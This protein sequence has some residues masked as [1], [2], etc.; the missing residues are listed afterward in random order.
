MAGVTVAPGADLDPALL[1]F[2]KCHVTS[3]LNW[4][5]L[6]LLAAQEGRWLGAEDLLR[7]VH[8][9]RPDVERA[10]RDLARD[11]IVEELRSGDPED[12]SFRLPRHEPTT[13]VLHRL[14]DTCMRSQELRNIIVAKIY[15]RKPSSVAVLPTRR[16]TLAR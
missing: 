14:I 3:V 12:S 8:R 13:V 11:G 7:G 4:D 2:V 16:R 10:L 15:G 6:R 1:A 9:E 5:L